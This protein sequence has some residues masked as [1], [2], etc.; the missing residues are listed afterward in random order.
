MKVRKAV[1]R[2]RVTDPWKGKLACR[3]SPPQWQERAL[4]NGCYCPRAH[5]TGEARAHQPSC[6]AEQR[7]SRDPSSADLQRQGGDEGERK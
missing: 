1:G 5:P 3:L 7:P 6:Q 2:E 4:Q